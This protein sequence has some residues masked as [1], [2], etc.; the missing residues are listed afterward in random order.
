[1]ALT[2]FFQ[3]ILQELIAI[4][5]E[6]SGDGEEI[7]RSTACSHTV[8]TA[9]GLPPMIFPDQTDQDVMLSVWSVRLARWDRSKAPRTFFLLAESQDFFVPNHT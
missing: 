2:E 8:V 3:R 5:M 4:W 6:S 1:M 7:Q 9:L